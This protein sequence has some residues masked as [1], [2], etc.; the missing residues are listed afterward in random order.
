MA[1]LGSNHFPPF[2]ISHH[3]N[4]FDCLKVIK[5]LK[6]AQKNC[7]TWG[8]IYQY[9]EIFEK[10]IEFDTDRL[11]RDLEKEYKTKPLPFLTYH[12]SNDIYLEFSLHYK[13]N[14]R[15]R[16]YKRIG[17]PKYGKVKE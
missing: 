8:F 15:K 9:L 13:N 12:Y 7:P 14:S 16:F 11:C 1:Q 2:T 6:Q 10:W 3:Q 4:E 5:I 17:F